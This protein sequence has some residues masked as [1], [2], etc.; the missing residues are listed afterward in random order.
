MAIAFARAESEKPFGDLAGERATVFPSSRLALRA[1]LALFFS[2]AL[3]SAAAAGLAYWAL[4]PPVV[5][6]DD[7]YVV[8]P[9][10]EVAPQID[11]T[12]AQILVH[13]TQYVHRGKILVMLDPKDAELD[14]QSALAAYEEAMR[15]AQE[16]IAKAKA[17]RAN[18]RI[19]A[20]LVQQARLQFQRRNRTPGA[21]SG[22][23]ASNAQTALTTAKYELSIAEND[24]VAAEAM[25]K[26]L[27]SSTVPAVE[28][29]RIGLARA[30]L[31]LQR[32]EIRAAVDGV[33]AQLHAQAGQ[34]VA[35]GL[36]LM[37]IVP[38]RQLYV[39]ANFKESQIDDIKVGQRAYLTSD[40]YGSS[41]IFHGTVDGIG[42][43]TGAVFSIL[44][45]QNASG[46]WI[47]VVQRV[48]VR[49]LLDAADLKQ[50]PLRVGL[51]MN[52]TVQ[53]EEPASA[54]VTKR[55]TPSLRAI[56]RAAY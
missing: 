49:I 16:R 23:E 28:I 37:S 56:A 3:C 33:V 52:A 41:K 11:G 15:V 19:K 53:V 25:V 27:N 36:R 34:Q 5:S 43:G 4:Q 18:V 55:L 13:D 26:E 35:P 48:P 17:A 20:A 8:A 21:V 22:E 54:V 1:R 46:N 44:P 24:A 14:H 39:E 2:I 12:I 38:I 32:T 40:L 45:A 29:A 6:T 30:I 7:A 31:R 51:S 47:K 42:G 50:N 9:L 10:A